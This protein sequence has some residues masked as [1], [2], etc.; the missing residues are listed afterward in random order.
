[1]TKNKIN[2]SIIGVLLIASIIATILHDKKSPGSNESGTSS[3]AVV[4]SS[5]SLKV[6]PI[7]EGWGYKI[8]LDSTLYI[9]QETIPGFSGNHKF[10]SQS[11]AML[12]GELVIKKIKQDKVPFISVE[13]LDSL[14]INYQ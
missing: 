1:M 5:V 6:Y 4:P 13:E 11:D 3:I 8:Y 9:F 7:N 14:K 10:K 2:L 12:C